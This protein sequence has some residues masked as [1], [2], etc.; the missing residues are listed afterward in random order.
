M[1]FKKV[2]KGFLSSRWWWFRSLHKHMSMS[3]LEFK[4]T[5]DWVP[6]SP[7]SQSSFQEGENLLLLVFKQIFLSQVAQPIGLS[8]DPETRQDRK[9]GR[10]NWD[11]V[12]RI[13]ASLLLL[14]SF[15]VV[16]N[17]ARASKAAPLACQPRTAAAH[18]SDEETPVV[19][20][21]ALV[22]A[23]WLPA[24]AKTTLAATAAV[25]PPLLRSS[26]VV[27]IMRRRVQSRGKGGLEKCTLACWADVG[28]LNYIIIDMLSR[29]AT[30]QLCGTHMHTVND[31]TKGKQTETDHQTKELRRLEWAKG[32][33]WRKSERL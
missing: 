18:S 15:V 17:S 19:T 21:P 2:L 14:H 9:S 11:Q 12:E 5:W 8:F 23:S 3:S 33:K 16:A 28:K 20:R 29:E 1:F 22:P 25:P 10:R 13:A 32:L 4:L 30:A 7:L 31:D 24:L 6:F 26:S 27:E